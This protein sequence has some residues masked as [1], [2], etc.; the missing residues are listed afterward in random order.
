M[1]VGARA[2]GHWGICRMLGLGGLLCVA[3]AS[4][5]SGVSPA[6]RAM[7]MRRIRSSWV[8]ALYRVIADLTST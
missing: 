1:P 4:L 6:W 8:A 2:A 3:V 5:L 7:A